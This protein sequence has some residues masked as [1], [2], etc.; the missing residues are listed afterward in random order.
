L[1]YEV[2]YEVWVE[3]QEH[4]STRGLID[5]VLRLKENLDEVLARVPSNYRRS[6]VGI[7]K[8]TGDLNNTLAKVAAQTTQLVV[9]GTS[10]DAIGRRIAGLVPLP[11]TRARDLKRVVVLKPDH[12]Y[13]EF[14]LEL[15]TRELYRMGLVELE[16]V[17][18]T[19]TIILK[20]PRKSVH[21]KSTLHY[22]RVADSGLRTEI[23]SLI[24]RMVAHAI[25]N[26]LN[27]SVKE[28][29]GNT[30]HVERGSFTARVTITQGF[31]IV[32]VI[33]ADYNGITTLREVEGHTIKGAAQSIIKTLDKA[34]TNTK[35]LHDKLARKYWDLVSSGFTV[36][37]TLKDEGI[38]GAE[39][40]LIYDDGRL[41][42]ILY[43]S[44][45]D[46]RP[47]LT[48]GEV[49]KVKGVKLDGPETIEA[50]EEKL[51][52]RILE[53]TN[54]ESPPRRVTRVKQAAG[55]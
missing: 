11:A 38:D 50:P 44:Y 25:E 36:A 4:L 19:Y 43:G 8:G 31:S 10:T 16:A 47:V 46:G 1:A 14:D 52:R 51:G 20:T 23:S 45:N 22:S 21:L 37:S 27:Y 6:I 54:R 15:L 26:S 5:T 12:G 42:I 35:T 53:I 29:T 28:A 34:Y 9:V 55:G 48:H 3:L 18:P 33:S 7:A 13:I 30:I 41:I 49:Y 32:A 40:K 24:A 39:F 2:P 17:Y